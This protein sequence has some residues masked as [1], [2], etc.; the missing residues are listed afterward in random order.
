[1]FPPPPGPFSN[2]VRAS[3]YGAAGDTAQNARDRDGAP[4]LGQDVEETHESTPTA[5][6]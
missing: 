5:L 4:V 6:A 3:E 1:M 2:A